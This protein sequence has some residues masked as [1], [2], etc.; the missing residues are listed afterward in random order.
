MSYSQNDEEDFIVQFFAG[1]TGTFLD[2]GAFDGV[3]LSNTRRLLELGWRGVLV[4]PAAHNFVKL[5][6]NCQPYADQV[7]LVQAAVSNQSILN[8]LTRL[9][10]DDTPDRPW[11]TTINSGLLEIGSVMRPSPLNVQVPT[12]SINRL[13]TFGPFHFISIDAEW[14]D[15]AILKEMFTTQECAMICVE[16]RNAMEREEM[17][18]LLTS[19]AGYGFTIAKETPENIIATRDTLGL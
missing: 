4:E 9:W 18:G 6:A 3:G 1:R 17:K 14:E 11:S 7:I 13:L 10:I 5:M 8:R 16:P 12:I 15:L 19:K 2:V